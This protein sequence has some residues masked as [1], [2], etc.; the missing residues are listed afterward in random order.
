VQAHTEIS[1]LNRVFSF[2]AHLQAMPWQQQQRIK[3]SFQPTEDTNQFEK[4][5]L[6]IPYLMQTAYQTLFTDIFETQPTKAAS[7]S[8]RKL[9]GGEI[10]MLIDLEDLQAPTIRKSE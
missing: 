6:R 8:L 5:E 1:D 3:I 10:G 4:N 9:S 2:Y 7:I